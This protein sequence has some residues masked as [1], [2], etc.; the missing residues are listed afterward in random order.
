MTGG[1]WIKAGN[2]KA[3]F[4]FN[5]GFKPGSS[6]PEVH[7]NYVDHNTGMQMKATSITAEKMNR[8]IICQ[9]FQAYCVP[10]Q[11]KASNKGTAK[12]IRAAAPE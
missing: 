5:A 7:F 8:P 6:T 12:A 9:E 4:G 1:G 10:A 11:E 3:N 2:S